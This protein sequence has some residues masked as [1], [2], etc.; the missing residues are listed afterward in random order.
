M[1]EYGVF[2]FGAEKAFA[3]GAEFGRGAESP[4]VLD[5]R[6][7]GCIWLCEFGNRACGEI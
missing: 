1:Q 6:H 7:V 2:Q 4:H 3:I 5:F